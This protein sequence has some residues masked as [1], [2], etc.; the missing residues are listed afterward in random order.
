MILSIV[1]LSLVRGLF[2]SVSPGGVCQIQLY[3][4]LELKG[5]AIFRSTFGEMAANIFKVNMLG[6]DNYGQ[7]INMSFFLAAVPWR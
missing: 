6:L 5:W 7:R 2:S 1:L 3:L 4:I